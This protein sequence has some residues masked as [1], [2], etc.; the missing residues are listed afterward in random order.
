MKV[1]LDGPNKMW[2]HPWQLVHRARLHDVLKET[3][4]SLGAFLNTSSKV[5]KVDP[6]TATLRLEGG[7]EIKADF[8]VGADG[9]YVSSLR[10]IRVS[11]IFDRK[12]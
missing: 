9:I 8:I 4:T 6:V 5:L 11:H 12:F 3:A 2:Q 1:P 10:D 7:R